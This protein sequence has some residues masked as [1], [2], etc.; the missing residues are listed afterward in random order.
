MDPSQLQ[1]ILDHFNRKFD[2]MEARWDRRFSPP[3]T[4]PRDAVEELRVGTTTS[5][6]SVASAPICNTTTAST[7]KP[8][9][10][11]A[12][13]RANSSVAREQRVAAVNFAD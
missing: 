3:L 2:E 9:S 1:I 11:P 6:P 8:S 7:D 5:A 13:A 12:A 10:D 4:T